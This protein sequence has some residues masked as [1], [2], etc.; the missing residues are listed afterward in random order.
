[1][2]LSGRPESLI[3]ELV[4]RQNDF[5]RI[6][7]QSF[8]VIGA[9]TPSLTTLG[10]MT[11]GMLSPTLTIKTKHSP[12]DAERPLL[13]VSRFYCHAECR[14]AECRATVLRL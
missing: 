7:I 5:R 6:D 8:G 1:M 3:G 11:F 13:L 4:F 2:K 10:I 12:L 9:T 14:C